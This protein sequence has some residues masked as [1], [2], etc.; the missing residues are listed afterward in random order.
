VHPVTTATGADARSGL[1]VH[2]VTGTTAERS[3]GASRDAIRLLAGSP[4]VGA[5]TRCTLGAP[6]AWGREPNGPP[7]RGRRYR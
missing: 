4:A 2:P 3:R 6:R 1:G 7:A 5:L